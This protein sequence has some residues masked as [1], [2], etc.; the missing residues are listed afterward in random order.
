[1]PYGRLSASN[2]NR[3]HEERSSGI[4]DDGDGAHNASFGDHVIGV[5]DNVEK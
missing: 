2:I 5:A 3:H 4:D 1:M